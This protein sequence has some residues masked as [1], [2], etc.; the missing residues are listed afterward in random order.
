MIDASRDYSRVTAYPEVDRPRGMRT[1]ITSG[2]P[3]IL[4]LSHGGSN[5]KCR[6]GTSTLCPL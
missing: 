4:E 6:V 1:R 3:T 5:R 2:L